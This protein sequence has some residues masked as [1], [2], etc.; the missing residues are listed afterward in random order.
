MFDVFRNDSLLHIIS[1][2][3]Q[4]L[5]PSWNGGTVTITLV[6]YLE[7]YCMVW[8]HPKDITNILA[9]VWAKK[10]CRITYDNANGN[11]LTVHKD[12]GEIK[13]FVESPQG[14]YWINTKDEDGT[15]IKN[16][17]YNHNNNRIS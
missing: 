14:L 16:V 5:H 1:Q 15:T 9:L 8:Y 13:S 11:W 2:S 12:N 3:G 6:G 17:E 7:G 10:N 4:N